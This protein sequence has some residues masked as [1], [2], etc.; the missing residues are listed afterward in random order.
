MIKDINEKDLV[1]KRE[2]T[3]YTGLDDY[4]KLEMTRLS[5]RVFAK[6]YE[7]IHETEQMILHQKRHGKTKN[8]TQQRE[9]RHEDTNK[10]KKWCKYQKTRQHDTS[11]CRKLNKQS[12]NDIK[13]YTIGETHVKP[14]NI[15]LVVN[16]NKKTYDALKNGFS[17]QLH[18]KASC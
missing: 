8:S 6:M 13:N 9:E 7:V 11:E 17:I 12:S 2:E 16:I 10:N 3:F 14:R 5:I 4:V 15:E 1:E 18:Y